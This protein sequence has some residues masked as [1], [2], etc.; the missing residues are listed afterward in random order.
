[1]SLGNLG[2]AVGAAVQGFQQQQRQNFAEEEAIS[3]RNFRERGMK[4]QEQEAAGRQKDRSRVEAQQADE[5]DVRKE[6][7][8]FWTRDYGTPRDVVVG[9]ADQ[10]TP[11]GTV[12]KVPITKQV[13]LAPGDDPKVDMQHYRDIVGAV[14]KRGRAS[15]EQMQAFV[16]KFDN[17]RK[18]ERGQALEKIMLGDETAGADF[19]V[20]MGKDPSK[21]KVDY[22]AKTI[23]FGDGGPAMDLKAALAMQG[24]AEQYRRMIGVSKDSMAERAGNLGIENVASEIDERKQLL[25]GKLAGQAATTNLANS[26]AARERAASGGGGKTVD[27][28]SLQQMERV[29]T[30]DPNYKS[31]GETDKS[32]VQTAAQR[33][34]AG[35]STPQ[36]AAKEAT[37][38]YSRQLQ[39][40]R[41]AIKAGGLKD[42]SGKP[43][44][45][46]DLVASKIGSAPA[47]AAAS[48]DEE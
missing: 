26:R 14:A 41:A 17:A 38:W 45:P 43:M 33:I 30:S 46:A 42:K 4:M 32:N 27:A 6:T 2:V 48:T 25:P 36:A 44:S 8:A 29:F 15:P 24:T 22:K 47:A 19:A 5:D 40:A 3:S 20:S 35:G 37:A 11:D 34:L 39:A 28:K 10:A 16:E 18:T 7:A 12:V 31:L 13:K 21:V 9:Q 23:S 1:M